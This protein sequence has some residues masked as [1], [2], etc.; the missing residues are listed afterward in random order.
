MHIVSDI[1]Q[2]DFTYGIAAIDSLLQ[3]AIKINPSFSLL[4]HC[5]STPSGTG[6]DLIMCRSM[7]WEISSYPIRDTMYN[8]YLLRNEFKGLKPASWR[9]APR[10]VMDDYQLLVKG[11]GKSQQIEYLKKMV[12]QKNKWKLSEKEIVK[13]P[14][15]TYRFYKPKQI[16]LII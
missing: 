7:G 10:M 2:Q 13:E 14:N 4:T 12:D 3:S 11:A 1:Y 16:H 6:Y 5:S 9:F 8:L 15:G